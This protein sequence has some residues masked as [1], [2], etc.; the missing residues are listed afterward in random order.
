MRQIGH[1]IR[2]STVTGGGGT[3]I[4]DP[5]TG[6]QT[7]T[8][9]AATD[10]DVEAAVAAARDAFKD[11]SR[12][13]LQQRA[14]MMIELGQAL[15]RAREELT[16][17]VVS[18][19]GKTRADAAAEVE[20]AIE[21]LGQAASVGTWYG[22]PFSPGVSRG[23][24]AFEVR[25]PIGVVA[26]ISPF[27]FPVL[28][29]VVQAAMAI[30]CGNTVVLKPSERDPG[31]TVRIAELFAEAGL[32]AGVL[33]VVLGGKT[34]VDRLVEHPDI[35]GV[36]FVGST[37]VAHAIRVAGVANNKR[38]QAFGGGKNH[39]VVLPDSDISMAAD[40][41]VSAAFG[42]AGQRCMAVSVVVAVGLIADALVA[43]IADR[44]SRL[45]TGRAADAGSDVGPVIT[46]E[47]RDRIA[48][49]L[50]GVEAEGGVLRAGG[51]VVETEDGWYI[52]PTLID[53]VKPGMAV[54]SDELFGPVLSVVRVSSYEEAAKIIAGH[55]LGNGAAIFTR[56]GAIARRFIDETEAGQIGVNVPIPFPVFFHNFGGWKDSAF[57]ETKL[58]GPGAI[59]FHTR[60][61]TVTSRWPDPAS[62][63]VDLGFP[64]A[65]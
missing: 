36:S 60:T 29:P 9:A 35:A 33:N 27:N 39:M 11:W 38:V 54:H 1:F 4:Y 34:V 43:A 49:Y 16:D 30:A 64:R 65:H 52:A 17:L 31:A 6:T 22:A 20:R 8:A 59:A 46:R 3:P 5:S 58:F 10:E 55:P 61:K 42:A 41:A 50:K 51:G 37:P 45:Q 26:A 12:T 44:V 40:A 25:Y 53:H 15:R 28:I 18:E 57:T 19:L 21:V 23:I 62:S 47:S 56:D 24:D 7:A 13:G 63:K 2:G 48:H 32:P 14:G